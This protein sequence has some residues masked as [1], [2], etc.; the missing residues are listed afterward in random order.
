MKRLGCVDLL[1]MQ[2]PDVVALCLAAIAFSL[3][4]LAMPFLFGVNLFLKPFFGRR[5]CKGI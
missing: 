2:H 5:L 3:K 1:L 4:L